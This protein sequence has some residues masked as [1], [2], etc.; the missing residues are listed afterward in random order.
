MPVQAIDLNK[1]IILP[2]TEL[3]GPELDKINNIED[4][5]H[6]MKTFKILATRIREHSNE[7]KRL[8]T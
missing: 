8:M 3:L 4:Y 2:S 7:L 1:T 5:N 6:R